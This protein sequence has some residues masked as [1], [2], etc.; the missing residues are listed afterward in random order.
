MSLKLAHRG[1]LVVAGVIGLL[2]WRDKHC[3]LKIARGVS[4]LHDLTRSAP[5]A[6]RADRT[7]AA[8]L[9][10][11]LLRLSSCIVLMLLNL[12]VLLLFQVRVG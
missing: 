3:V 7:T 4:H 2:L 6:D 12:H 8:A 11:H 9:G 10:L 5:L 1:Q